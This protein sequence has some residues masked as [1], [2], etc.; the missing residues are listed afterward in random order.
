MATA[1]TDGVVEIDGDPF[2]ILA[3][4]DYPDE[5]VFRAADYPSS[6]GLAT[7][8]EPVREERR[9]SKSDAR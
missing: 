7:E 8:D 9:G 6:V 3:G 4:D 1:A 2:L 5:G